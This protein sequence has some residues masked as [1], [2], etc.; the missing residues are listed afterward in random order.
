MP[1]YLTSALSWLV[2]LLAPLAIVMLIVRLLLTP[3]FLQV[4]YRL[5]GFPEDPYGFSMA[6]R[7]RWA[8]PS[9]VYLVNDAGIDYLG[10]LKFDNG[11]PIYNERELSHMLDVKKVVQMLLNGWMVTLFVLAALAVWAWRANWL[12]D[13]RLGW[14]RGGFLTAG[15]LLALS[16]FAALS[17]RQ[18]FT[19]FHGVFFSGDSWLFAYTDT[20]I[21]LFPIRFWMD[22]TAFIVGVSFIIGLMLGLGLK[23]ARR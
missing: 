2:T 10:N 6:D 5:P 12:A 22:C 16:L 23:P 13:Y 18:F 20:L 1:R 17:F 7:L 19:A 21:R 4:E 3:I 8:T 9:L 15:L 14:Q 11:Q